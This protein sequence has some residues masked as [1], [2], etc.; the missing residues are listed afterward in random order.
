MVAIQADATARELRALFREQEYS[1][2]PVYKENLDN[3]LGIMRV[4]DLFG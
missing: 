2:F 1:R 3:I 4:K